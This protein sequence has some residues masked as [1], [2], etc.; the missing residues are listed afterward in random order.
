VAALTTQV[1]PHAG[2][3]L[4]LSDPTATTG[5][6]C[7]TGAGVFLLVQNGSGAPINVVMTT[8][9]VIDGD[10]SVADRTIAVA[11]SKTAIIPVPALYRNPATG[12]ATVTC[13]S[14]TTVKIACVRV[15]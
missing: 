5:D 3:A 10:L 1:A 2:V 14:V 9:S 7:A 12:L 13:S 15:P 4:T 6:T 11:D 8:P